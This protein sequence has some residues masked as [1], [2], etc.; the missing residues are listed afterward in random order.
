MTKHHFLPCCCRL[1]ASASS[2]PLPLPTPMHKLARDRWWCQGIITC[3]V[4][5]INTRYK[6]LHCCCRRHCHCA[7]KC[8]T[9]NDAAASLPA[10]SLSLTCMSIHTAAALAIAQASKG[11]VMMPRHH[12]WRCLCCQPTWRCHC[13]HRCCY[14]SVRAATVAAITIAEWGTGD[15]AEASLPALPLRLLSPLIG[16][17]RVM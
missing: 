5:V 9:G 3:T 2:V 11:Q 4:A 13:H 15:G 6:R 10:L 12:H 8:G 7:G 14:T 1:H 17:A 16:W